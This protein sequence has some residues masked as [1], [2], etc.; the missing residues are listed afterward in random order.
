MTMIT[1]A[2]DGDDCDDSDDGRMKEMIIRKKMENRGETI[3]S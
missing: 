1:D 2:D 3:A